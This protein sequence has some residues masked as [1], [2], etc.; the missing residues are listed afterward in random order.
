MSEEAA[1]R[2][3]PEDAPIE[4]DD[5]ATIDS[6]YGDDVDSLSTSITSS[7]RAYR[8][9]NGRRYHAFKDGSYFFPNDDVENDRLD[10]QHAIFLKSLDGKLYL[11][12]VPK[13]LRHVLDVGTG[14][15][16]VS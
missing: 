6:A 7:V 16:I 14:T 2:A 1:P 5:T 12:P 9:E 13:D 15:G 10:L 4:V 11:S 3:A 8:I